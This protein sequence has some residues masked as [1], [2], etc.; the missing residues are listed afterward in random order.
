LQRLQNADPLTNQTTALHAPVG[1][2]SE[3]PEKFYRLVEY[4]CPAPR[5]AELFA[6]STRPNWDGHGDELYNTPRPAR[7]LH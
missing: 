5:Y 1:K 2:H 6:R 7:A 3:K 4:L